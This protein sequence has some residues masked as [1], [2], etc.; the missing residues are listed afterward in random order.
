MMSSLSVVARTAPAS[1]DGVQ[2]GGVKRSR[3]LPV[4][5]AREP[6]ETPGAIEEPGPRQIA[7]RLADG[8][9]GDERAAAAASSSI[10]RSRASVTLWMEDE[11]RITIRKPKTKM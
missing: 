9:R 8:E 7:T 6:A 4:R 2:L 3:V 1:E 5:I 10:R 11:L